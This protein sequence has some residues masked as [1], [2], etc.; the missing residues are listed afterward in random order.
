MFCETRRH[1]NVGGVGVFHGPSL[2]EENPRREA[3]MCEVCGFDEPV[4]AGG[5]TPTKMP[6]NPSGFSHSRETE[7]STVSWEA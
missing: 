5:G 7:M 2:F 3:E 1:S 6:T 4:F